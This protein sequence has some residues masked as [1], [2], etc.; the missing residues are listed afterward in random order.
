[1]LRAPPSGLCR[2]HLQQMPFR[3]ESFCA[4]EDQR[5]LSATDI[6]KKNFSIQA[7]STMM[8]GCCPIETLI[9][10]PSSSDPGPEPTAT[11]QRPSGV[12][13]LVED[14]RHQLP[15]TV[16][17]PVGAGGSARVSTALDALDQKISSA[18]AAELPKLIAA[19]GEIIKQ[20]ERLLDGAERRGSGRR[21]FYA[22]V[23]FSIAAIGVGTGLV[24]TGFGLPGFFLIGGSAA[25]YVPDYV[26]TYFGRNKSGGHDADC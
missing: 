16:S 23:A 8:I 6:S 7:I 18:S 24:A 22:K 14:S 25:V 5:H 11:R 17:W 20:D 3:A 2:R 15:A 13:G 26:R 9:D 12:S 1:V 4:F 19:R 10:M 21:A